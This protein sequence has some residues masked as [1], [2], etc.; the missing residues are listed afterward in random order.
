MTLLGGMPFA[1]A[2][3]MAP[4]SCLGG[5][6]N[7]CNLSLSVP[8]KQRLRLTR[9]QLDDAQAVVAAVALALTADQPVTRDQLP[10][11]L[12]DKLFAPPPPPRAP[13]MVAPARK[14]DK[15]E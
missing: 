12:R 3:V 13:A 11:N 8:G 6:R 14:P 2:L 9:L 10:E 1:K 15:P 7:P 5:C 4:T